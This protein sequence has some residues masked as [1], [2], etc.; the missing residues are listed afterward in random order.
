MKLE[1]AFL[2][3]RFVGITDSIQQ[4]R[5]WVR[6]GKIKATIERKKDGY[7]IDPESLENFIQ[8]RTDRYK[9]YFFL[10]FEKEHD[11]DAYKNRIAE[12]EKEVQHLKDKNLYLRRELKGLRNK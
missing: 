5:K 6:E 9:R 3:L 11:I 7:D 8:E 10:E 4:V 1:D 12:L 2:K